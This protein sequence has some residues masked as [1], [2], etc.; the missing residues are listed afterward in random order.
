MQIRE[1]GFYRKDAK[2]AKIIVFQ[3][4]RKKNRDDF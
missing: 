4:T 1:N 3:V 2:G